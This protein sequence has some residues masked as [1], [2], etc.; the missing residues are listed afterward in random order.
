M[1]LSLRIGPKLKRRLRRESLSS[2]IVHVV[3][4]ECTLRPEEHVCLQRLA[5][6]IK[7]QAVVAYVSD[8]SDGANLCA[9]ELQHD[10]AAESGIGVRR[11]QRPSVRFMVLCPGGG[12]LAFDL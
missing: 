12:E 2:Q 4:K 7:K 11:R 6:A 8:S 10:A 3:P 1:S 5:A 9:C